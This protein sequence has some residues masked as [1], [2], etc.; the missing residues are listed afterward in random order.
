MI[1]GAMYLKSLARLLL[2]T[3][4]SHSKFKEQ[5]SACVL[6]ALAPLHRQSMGAAAQRRQSSTP[7][8]CNRTAHEIWLER[9]SQNGNALEHATDELKG[10]TEIVMAAV[11][12]NG[13]ALEYATDELKG[14]RK[15]V[16]AA[17]SK[18]GHA[19]QYAKDELKGDR[20]IVMMAVSSVGS[21]LRYS[22]E[23]LKDD[24]EM[25]LHALKQSPRQLV[26]LRVAL[27]SGRVCT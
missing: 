12:Q 17:V 3:C 19:L 14:D 16:M 7:E 6:S 2:T 18:N 20:E 13:R 21:A 8:Q 24:K 23:E 15:I 4:C 10:D 26:G 1:L 5:N 9:V 25:M 27:L 11:S 22:P